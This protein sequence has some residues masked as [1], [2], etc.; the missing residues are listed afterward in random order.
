M[1]FDFYT[2]RQSFVDTPIST[3]HLM[4][5]GKKKKTS[6]FL[7]IYNL[8]HK[9]EAF[10]CYEFLIFF[11]LADSLTEESDCQRTVLRMSNKHQ[12]SLLH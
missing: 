11:H 2:Q 10:Q 5:W 1:N 6:P 8:L 12:Q 9:K 4:F 7:L 3:I